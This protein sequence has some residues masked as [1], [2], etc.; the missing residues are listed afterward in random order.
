M[1]LTGTLCS[2]VLRLGGV[3]C[4]RTSERFRGSLERWRG[5]G[6]SPKGRRRVRG[7]GF[8]TCLGSRRRS[9][10]PLSVDEWFWEVAGREGCVEFWRCARESRVE[11]WRCGRE[12]CGYHALEAFAVFLRGVLSL[13]FCIFAFPCSRASAA[14]A[15]PG[16]TRLQ[17]AGAGNGSAAPPPVV[18]S[19]QLA[20][21]AAG[22]RKAVT[23]RGILVRPNGLFPPGDA[24][25]T[26]LSASSSHLAFEKALPGPNSPYEGLPRGGWATGDAA[27]RAGLDLRL[28]LVCDGAS[29]ITIGEPDAGAGAATNPTSSSLSSPPSSSCFPGRFSLLGA[30]R[31]GDGAGIGDGFYLSAHGGAVETCLDEATAELAKC[32]WTPL[33]STVEASFRLKKAVP[34]HKTLEV[35]CSI[36]DVKGLRCF[37]EGGIYDVGEGDGEAG[38]GGVQLA[39]CAATLVDLKR[40]LL[41]QR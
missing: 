36:K 12:G 22:Y 28:F 1:R 13:S 33:L 41:A 34:L 2:N 11:F 31:F 8:A 37:V 23:S 40:L 5:V 25:L 38:R 30:V 26:R 32:A 15:L 10:P 3:D 6:G 4:R 39:T 17:S 27:A 19:N 20:C 7:A 14:M 9:S 35:R 16:G 24:V 21:E 18:V 29:E